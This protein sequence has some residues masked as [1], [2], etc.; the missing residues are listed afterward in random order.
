MASELRWVLLALSAVLLIGIWWW[1]V[2]RARQSPGNAHLRESGAAA[3][4]PGPTILGPTIMSPAPEHHP[5]D[6]EKREWGVPPFEPLNIRTADFDQGQVID[7]PMSATADPLDM[8]LNMEYI[9]HESARY[10]DA[11]DALPAADFDEVEAAPTPVDAPA[12]VERPATGPA[13]A[14]DAQPASAAV[15][16]APAD[17]ANTS[18][19]QRIVT[20]RVCAVGD[21]HW[22]GADLLAALESHGL[23]FGRYK[24]FHR[25]HHDGRTLFCA[26]SLVEPGSFDIAR[27]ADEEFRGL[28]LFAVLPG[29]ADALETIDTLI[30]TALDLADALHGAVQDAQGAPLSAQRAEAL[31]ADV[32]Q[33]QQ[34][35]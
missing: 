23:K 16:P 13:S 14:P 12:G 22:P 4:G 26:A 30:G 7:L 28:T 29:P 17:A 2:R 25:M 6:A 21:A 11:D 1:G 20:V 24:V 10:P 33:F 35:L 3:A 19:T 34:S 9:E 5:D 31:R 8:T 18:E 32:A 27:M 15:A